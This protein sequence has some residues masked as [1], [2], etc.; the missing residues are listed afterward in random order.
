MIVT[1]MTTTGGETSNKNA[2]TYE[3]AR[4]RADE[5]SDAAGQCARSGRTLGLSLARHGAVVSRLHPPPRLSILRHA[6]LKT[7]PCLKKLA[8][9]CSHAA[10]GVV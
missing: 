6:V 2:C 8:S 10:G 7:M 5:N 3:R 1:T 9:S 4:A